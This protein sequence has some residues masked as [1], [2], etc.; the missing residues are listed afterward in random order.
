LA[1]IPTHVV[2]DPNLSMSALLKRTPPSETNSY[3]HEKTIAG[4]TYI[5]DC[6]GNSLVVK[7]NGGMEEPFEDTGHALLKAQILQAIIKLGPCSDVFAEDDG[8][9][10]S[11]FQFI[12][13][14][15]PVQQAM[16]LWF[17]TIDEEMYRYYKQHS[18][19]VPMSISSFTNNQNF[20]SLS[21]LEGVEIHNSQGTNEMQGGWMAMTC[22]GAFLGGDLC[23]PDL[24]ISLRLL[25]GDVV[26]LLSGIL[27]YFISPI[28][29]ERKALM[30]FSHDM[31]NAV[32]LA[33][34]SFK[35]ISKEGAGLKRASV[36]A[37]VWDERSQRF[38]FVEEG[39]WGPPRVEAGV[40]VN[41]GKNTPDMALP[42]Y[43]TQ[44]EDL[45][46]EQL[47]KAQRR[48]NKFLCFARSEVKSGGVAIEEVERVENTP[49]AAFYLLNAVE[50]HRYKM[51]H[52]PF[53]PMGRLKRKRERVGF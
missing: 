46:P 11:R 35:G 23:L 38:R 41:W 49:V 14:T 15:A 47:F 24:D 50:R 44:E 36:K 13:E 17:E 52:Y 33:R 18:K 53:R 25:P 16:S 48:K 4:S 29:G 21:S 10:E 30:F 28:V 34:E 22:V 8:L 32:I 43:P 26:F 5:K 19:R 7:I 42:P 6:E 9:D 45:T 27:D 3:K 31:P 37:S 51:G 40:M 20:A 2:S 1:S 39:P 12:Q